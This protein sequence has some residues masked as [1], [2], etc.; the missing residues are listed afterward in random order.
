MTRDGS[1]ARKPTGKTVPSVIGTSP[2]MSPGLRTPTTRAMPS[3]C[4]TGSI[5]PSSTA[6]SARSL[7]SSAAYS[8]ATRLMSA[9]ARDS[10]ARCC[11]SSPEKSGIRAI[12]S[13]VTTA[14]S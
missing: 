9:A 11:S 5:L 13:D 3:L 2:K 8:P 12:S 14:G 1:A 4:L 6:K 10:R 7:P